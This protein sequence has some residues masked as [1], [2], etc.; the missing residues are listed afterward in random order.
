[1]ASGA[2][3]SVATGSVE[4]RHRKVIAMLAQHL[5]FGQIATA[6]GY[7]LYW[8]RVLAGRY[9]AAD[10]NVGVDRRRQSIG[11]TPLLTEAQQQELAVALQLPPPDGGRWTGANVAQWMAAKTGRHV[12]RQRGW[13]Y[14]RRLQLSGL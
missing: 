7:S 4:Q 11:A 14:L 6:T 13:E 12:H 2:R 1:M 8:V 5:P 3:A 10:P 9:A